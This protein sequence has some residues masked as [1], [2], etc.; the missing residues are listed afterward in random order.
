VI[1]AH[2]GQN[3]GPVPATAAGKAPLLT[4]ADDEFGEFGEFEEFGAAGG[5]AEAEWETIT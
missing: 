1:G 2:P 3:G 4:F 5:G